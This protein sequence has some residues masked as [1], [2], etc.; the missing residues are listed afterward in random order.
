MLKVWK[1]EGD[2]KE[3]KD[4]KYKAYGQVVF[5]CFFLFC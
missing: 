3:D 5:F 4:K 2:N 1:G